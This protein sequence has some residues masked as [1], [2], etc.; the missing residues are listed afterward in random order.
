M[1]SV[2]GTGSS[3]VI[4]TI[5][6]SKPRSRSR[7]RSTTELPPSPYVP[8]TSGSTSPI[9]T[10]ESAT[11]APSE[12]PVQLQERGV[13]R[14]HLDMPRRTRRDGLNGVV[15]QRVFDARITEPHREIRSALA[16][17]HHEMVDEML[18]IDVPQP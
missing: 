7:C 3:S 17:G 10:V 2:D 12:R 11:A 13:V 1:S 16:R 5:S 4:S 9:R 14:H 8:M 6:A 15:H 18:E